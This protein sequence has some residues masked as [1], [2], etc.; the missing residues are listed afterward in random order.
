MTVIA[1]QAKHRMKPEVTSHDCRR[2]PSIPFSTPAGLPA[3]P[4]PSAGPLSGR[5]DLTAGHGRLPSF[6]KITVL[7]AQSQNGLLVQADAM[8]HDLLCQI[9]QS[10]QEFR[11]LWLKSRVLTDLSSSPGLQIDPEP[12]RCPTLP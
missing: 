6:A 1:V 11:K 12:A 10:S 4:L 3:E 5:S 2:D 9:E 7:A 8:S